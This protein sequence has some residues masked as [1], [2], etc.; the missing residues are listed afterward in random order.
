MAKC[1]NNYAELRKPN[2]KRIQ[3]YVSIHIKLGN[4][5]VMTAEESIVVSAPR[6][7]TKRI[8]DRRR[9]ES[10]SHKEIGRRVCWACLPH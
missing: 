1:Q 9:S 8:G 2:K 6:I 3:P 7:G 5:N 4:S 10:E